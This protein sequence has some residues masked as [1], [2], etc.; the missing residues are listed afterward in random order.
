MFAKG[1]RN[2]DVARTLA[3][4]RDTARRYRDKYE[5]HIQSE[6]S[7][8]PRI[9]TDVLGNTIRVVEE[10]DLVRKDAWD[11]LDAD[12]RKRRHRCSECGCEYHLQVNEATALHKVIMDA[13]DK[14]MR[15][16]GLLG[17]KQE[18]FLHV[19]RIQLLQTK[20]IEFL[21]TELCDTDRQKFE[22]F[23][24]RELGAVSLDEPIDTDSRELPTAV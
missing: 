23:L 5:S 1:Y 12:K 22:R 10:I 6:V 9:L 13:A 15:L 21:Q 20:I 11:R 3:V 14:R 19:Q 8:N 24:T 17:V 4:S 2:I 7:E 16:F 18:Y